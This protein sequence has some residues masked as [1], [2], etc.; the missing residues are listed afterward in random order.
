M[1][2]NLQS[3]VL[4]RLPAC[5][6]LGPISGNLSSVGFGQGETRIFFKSK[7]EK[8]ILE[9]RKPVSALTAQGV[10]DESGKRRREVSFAVY[11]TGGA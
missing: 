3:C 4:V 5:S 11:P 2:Y 9:L 8:S 10:Q 7:D 6:I 1:Q